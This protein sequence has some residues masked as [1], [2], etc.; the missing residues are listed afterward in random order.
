MSDDKDLKKEQVSEEGSQSDDAQESQESQESVSFDEEAL[1]KV[2]AEC[3]DVKDKYLRLH[4]E[5][6]NAR[7]R[8]DRDRDELFKFSNFVIL[9]ELLPVLDTMESALKAAL[10]HANHDEVVK[11]LSIRSITPSSRCLVICQLD[12]WP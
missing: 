10:T 6:E 8:W 12:A 5:F 11:G 9:K 2:Q 3:L 4:A 1:T 7:K